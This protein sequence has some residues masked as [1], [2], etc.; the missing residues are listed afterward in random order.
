MFCNSNFRVVGFSGQALS[1]LISPVHPF[2]LKSNFSRNSALQ[3]DEWTF[4]AHLPRLLSLSGCVRYSALKTLR[5]IMGLVSRQRDNRGQ[6][7]CAMNTAV[8]YFSP[9]GEKYAEPCN[10]DVSCFRT[11]VRLVAP[12]TTATLLVPPVLCIT[13]ALLW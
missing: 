11:V 1:E 13:V 8:H 9:S 7:L 2:H 5:L 6:V 4:S 10:L 12:L 3:S